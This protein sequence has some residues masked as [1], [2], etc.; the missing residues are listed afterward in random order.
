MERPYRVPY[1]RTVGIAAFVSSMGIA[2]LFMPG[3]PA[4]LIWPYEWVIVG[5][6]CIFGAILM[7]LARGNKGEVPIH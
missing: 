1:G 5:G 4:A 2:V 3:S 6:W 7:W